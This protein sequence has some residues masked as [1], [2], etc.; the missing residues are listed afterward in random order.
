MCNMQYISFCGCLLDGPVKH[1]FLSIRLF[2][3]TRRTCRSIIFSSAVGFCYSVVIDGRRSFWSSGL[4]VFF[5]TRTTNYRYSSLVVLLRW[6]LWHLWKHH[7]CC[8]VSCSWALLFVRPKKIITFCVYCS[9]WLKSTPSQLFCWLVR[10]RQVRRRS[11]TTC[12]ILK[13]RSMP[14]TQV[15]NFYTTGVLDAINRNSQLFSICL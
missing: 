12:L 14:C 8:V 7:T 2:L 11:S 9:Q 10:G 15:C 4:P 3:A 5:F 1:W 6:T 13:T